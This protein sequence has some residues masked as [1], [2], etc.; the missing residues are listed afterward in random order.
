[1]LSSI[2]AAAS[3]AASSAV[4]A[5]GKL[6]SGEGLPFEK[7]AEVTSFAGKTPW[8]MYAGKKD[9]PEGTVKCSVFLYDIKTKKS[10]QELATVRNALKRLRTMKHPYLLKCIEGGEVLDQKGGGFI[11]ILTEPVQP[12]DDVLA[13]LQDTPGGLIWGVYTLAAAIK[14]L[15]IDCNIVHGQATPSTIDPARVPAP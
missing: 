2:A 15:N 4:S 9:R 11:Y 7:G 6:A 13:S 3:A 14:F 8:R 12:L 5:V 1:M 10:E